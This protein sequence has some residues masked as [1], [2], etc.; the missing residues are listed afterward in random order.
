[1]DIVL[2][3][4]AKAYF[5]RRRP[6][7]NKDDALGQMGPDV[8]SFPSGHASRAVF[9]SFFF[10]H[11][12]PMNIVFIIFIWTWSA[13]VCISR[14]LMNRHYILDVVGGC[15][16]GFIEGC[17]MFLLWLQDDTAKWLISFLS[18][19]KLDGGEFHV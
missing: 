16:L 13:S 14:I 12:Y 10:T 5:R 8:F 19:E 18:D 6:A 4:I 2:I 9:V 7:S 11:L 15:V 17:L 1:M 3:A